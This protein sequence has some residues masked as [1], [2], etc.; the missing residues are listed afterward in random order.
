M[1]CRPGEAVAVFC[2]LNHKAVTESLATCYVFVMFDNTGEEILYA[3][4]VFCVYAR[5]LEMKSVDDEKPVAK[6]ATLGVC[7]KYLSAVVLEQVI[8]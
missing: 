6:N 8:S 4:Q 7:L 5:S 3:L 1:N 2:R